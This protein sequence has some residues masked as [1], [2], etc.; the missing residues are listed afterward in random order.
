MCPGIAIEDGHGYPLGAHCD[1]EGVNFALFSAHAERVELCLFERTGR[2]EIHR[3]NLPAQTDQV[4]HGYVPGLKAGQLYGFRVYGPYEPHL[5]HR[6]NPHKLLL[7]PY[8]HMIQG[9]FQWDIRH[10]GYQLNHR[11]DQDL[12]PDNHDN[13]EMA[14]KSVV[15]GPFTQV[16][17]NGTG[18]RPAIPWS[19]TLIYETHVRGYTLTHEGLP[20]A[21]RGTFAGLANPKVIE[22]LKALGIST[23]ELM[24]IQYFIDEQFLVKRGLRN[25]WGYNPL[26]FFT[27]QPRYSASADSR[28]ELRQMVRCFHEAG[29]E[30]L[31]DVVYNHTAESNHL[32]PTLCFRGID[33]ASYY[34]LQTGDRRF[35]TNDTGCGNT[36]NLDH[37]RVLQ[38][39]MDSLRYWVE[40]VGIDG[41]RFDLASVLGRGKQ[42]FEREGGFF[43]AVHQDPVLNRVKLIAEPWDIGPDGYQLGNYPAGWG[44]WNDRYRD[45]V[46]RFWRGEEGVL[47]ELG[48]RL[49]GSSDLFEKN[50][51]CAWSSVN[52]LTSH[53]GFTLSDVVSYGQRHNQANGEDNCDGHT[54]NF[55]DNC[56]IEGDSQDPAVRA[57]RFHRRLNMLA[58]LLLS[59][60]TPMLLAGDEFG[61]SQQG[62]NN[63]YCQDNPTT[64]INWAARNEDD[65]RFLQSVQQL[66]G[67]RRQYPELHCNRF[68]HG[69]APDTG[70]G[71]AEIVWFNSSG[72]TMRDADWRERHL[73]CV[74]LLL[75]GE[76]IF[77][78]RTSSRGMHTLLMIFNASRE[79]FDFRLPTVISQGGWQRLLDTAELDCDEENKE[80]LTVWGAGT[81]YPLKANSSCLFVFAPQTGL[82]PTNVSGLD[83][84]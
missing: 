1:G 42:G 83:H 47:P 3:L 46:R 8:T 33:N 64:W 78:G 65:Q 81:T 60:G 32:G 58:T 16:G 44:E 43:K 28:Q 35:Y 72:A 69:R 61:N 71:V 55:S 52:Y 5:G 22:Y 51:R 20:L 41:F 70:D 14:L 4:W 84:D 17:D 50:G 11:E 82:S 6:F 79:W 73:R 57:L 56:G 48:K 31:L 39:V 23:V 75:N 38:L 2:R 26:N 29:I 25:Y 59:Q 15:V 7:D 54:T 36:L 21:E 37:P 10:F 77:A 49:R 27:P 13:A 34:R 45:T 76:G 24:P 19:E 53:D 62:N 67:L 9:E 68:I 12:I 74:G 30:V 66:I 40:Q 18:P 63:A 80:Q